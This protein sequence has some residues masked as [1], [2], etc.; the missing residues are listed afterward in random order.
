KSR[1][2]RHEKTSSGFYDFARA[3]GV[4]MCDSSRRTRRGAVRNRQMPNNPSAGLVQL[5]NNLT[6]PVGTDCLVIGTSFVSIELAGF[7]ISM[8]AS[9][10][11]QPSGRGIGTAASSLQGI[12]VRNG[13]ISNFGHAVDLDAGEG[14]IVE[15]LR[16]FGPSQTP[17]SV[18]IIARGIVRNNTVVGFF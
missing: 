11:L 12:A 4:N 8:V 1:K 7:S 10:P 5:V 2:R 18:G 17:F 6:A 9:T 14:S 15:E 3:W 16:L 13:S